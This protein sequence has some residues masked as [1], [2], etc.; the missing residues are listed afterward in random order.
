MGVALHSESR[1]PVSAAGRVYVA[2]LAA[3][4]TADFIGPISSSVLSGLDA[5]ALVVAFCA[6]FAVAFP[7][8]GRAAD[9]HPAGSVLAISLGGLAVGGLLLAVA[10][11]NVVVVAARALQG[12][13]AAVVP[14][15][16]QALLASRAGD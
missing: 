14:P 6:A 4:M 15:T 11:S 8:W 3:Y 12:A 13:A 1:V 5:G 7:F 16:A 10:P 2:T 9:R